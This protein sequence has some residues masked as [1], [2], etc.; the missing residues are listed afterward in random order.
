LTYYTTENGATLYDTK[1]EAIEEEIKEGSF[2]NHRFPHYPVVVNKHETKKASIDIMDDILLP[3]LEILDEEYGDIDGD[4][5]VPSEKMV[6]AAKQFGDVILEEY[7]VKACEITETKK[8]THEEVK[9]ILKKNKEKMSKCIYKEKKRKKDGY[10]Y[11]RGCDGIY[12]FIKSDISK[13]DIYCSKCGH[14][15]EV[16][17]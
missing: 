10:M 2:P 14:K 13:I 6:N 11:T 8:Y 9:D 1:K 7:V 17:K 3:I 16:K 4:G 15:I 5:T 12:F